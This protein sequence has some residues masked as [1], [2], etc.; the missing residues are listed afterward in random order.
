MSLCSERLLCLYEGV[1][2]KRTPRFGEVYHLTT[3]ASNP[4][5]VRKEKSFFELPGK[6]IEPPKQLPDLWPFVCCGGV[7]RFFDYTL[8]S[9]AGASAMAAV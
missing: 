1:S 3:V 8:A 4:V 6:I 9:L 7:P 5:I 2:K